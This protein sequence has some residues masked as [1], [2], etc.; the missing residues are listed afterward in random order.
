M[1][2]GNNTRTD[3]RKR[4]HVRI[5]GLTCCR[6]VVGMPWGCRF[7]GAKI[8]W[9]NAEAYKYI[10]VFQHITDDLFYVSNKIASMETYHVTFK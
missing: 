2:H 3:K 1:R 9:R 8:R 10:I 5:Q 4:Q 7:R 6:D